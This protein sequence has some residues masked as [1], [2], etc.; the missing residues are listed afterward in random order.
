ML[1]GLYLRHMSVYVRHFGARSTID[2]GRGSPRVSLP[3][4]ASTEQTWQVVC[5]FAGLIPDLSVH[6]V[7]SRRASSTLS[8]AIGNADAGPGRLWLLW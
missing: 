4:P 3:A 5:A 1:Q 8:S 2:T 6:D 7:T